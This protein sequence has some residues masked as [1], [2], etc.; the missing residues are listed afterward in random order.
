M[1]IAYE[2]AFPLLDRRIAAGLKNRSVMELR[3]QG[4]SFLGWKGIDLNLA[5]GEIQCLLGDSGSGKSLLLRAI[6]DLIENEGQVELDGRERETYSPQEWRRTVGFLPAEILWWERTVGE[7]FDKELPVDRLARLRLSEEA[8]AWEPSRLSMGERQR[9]GF[10]RLLDRE[11]SILL[12]DEPT[13]NLD[14][15]AASLVETE[16]F[17]YIRHREASALWVTH[18]LEQARRVASRVWRMKDQRLVPM[19]EE[20]GEL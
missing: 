15:E 18:S 10:A 4:L 19:E 7:H 12:L 17:E 5:A 8:F 14:E 16:I 2:R 13:A 9:L 11:P 1:R 3:I 20:G 6:A